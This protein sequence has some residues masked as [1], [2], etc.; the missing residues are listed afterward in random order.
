MYKGKVFPLRSVC[1]GASAVLRAR[2]ETACQKEQ[3]V[4][5]P[6]D[7]QHRLGQEN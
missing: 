4:A 5:A 3:A 2:G 7:R 6:L 1:V